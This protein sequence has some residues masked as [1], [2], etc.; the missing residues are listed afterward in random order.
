MSEVETVPVSDLTIEKMK[1]SVFKQFKADNKDKY[2]FI[3]SKGMDR[4]LVTDRN[5]VYTNGSGLHVRV[6]LYFPL[7]Q[8]FH[9]ENLSDPSKFRDTGKHT[10]VY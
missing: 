5:K 8:E 3:Y 1:P 2:F 7:K 10:S 6:G 9:R 4:W